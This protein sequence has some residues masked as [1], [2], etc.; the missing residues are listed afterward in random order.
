MEQPEGLVYQPELIP[1]RL[2]GELLTVF[3]T[4]RF[5]PIVIRG[6]AARRTA[7]HYGLDYDY[8]AR[9]PMPGEPVPDWLEPARA[10]AGGLA[11]FPPEEAAADPGQRYPPAPTIGWHCGAPR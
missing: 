4:L 9:T 3:E 7:R 11:G 10:I 2:E 5:E 8:E 6:Q 1:E